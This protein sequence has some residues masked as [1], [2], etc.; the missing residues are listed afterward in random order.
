[1][2]VG[3]S[4]TVAETGRCRG[5]TTFSLLFFCLFGFFSGDGPIKTVSAQAFRQ[6][7]PNPSLRQSEDDFPAM[8]LTGL[9]DRPASPSP[10]SETSSPAKETP[11]PEF[12]EKDAVP[13]HPNVETREERTYHPTQ[14]DPNSLIARFLALVP[15]KERGAVEWKIDPKTKALT[16]TAP[17]QLIATADQLIPRMDVNLQLSGNGVDFGV[18]AVSPPPTSLNR[19]QAGNDPVNG[20]N[21]PYY[22]PNENRMVE[23]RWQNKDAIFPTSEA[24]LGTTVFGA[25]ENGS[26][27]APPSNGPDVAVYAAAAN[28]IAAATAGL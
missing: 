17:P 25:D 2:P 24:E 3:L 13:R 18:A 14:S 27:D 11:L 22:D 19:K 21:R 28:Q 16:I 10:T 12:S 15:P 7:N 4:K 26:S 8:E 1:M 5:F 6:T 20:D 9:D 23:T